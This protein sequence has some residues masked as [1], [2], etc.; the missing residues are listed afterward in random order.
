MA[1]SAVHA[2]AWSGAHS[3]EAIYAGDSKDSVH[4]CYFHYLAIV[5]IVCPSG[6][7]MGSVEKVSIG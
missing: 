4:R 2:A 5:V 7:K 1:R 3:K 6:I